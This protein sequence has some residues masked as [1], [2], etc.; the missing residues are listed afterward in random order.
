MSASDLPTLTAAAPLPSTPTALTPSPLVPGDDAAAYDT[1]LA[2]ISATVRPAD[3]IEQAWVRDVVDL[4]FEAVRLRRLKA[5]LMTACA[6]EGIAQVLRGL[7][8]PGIPSVLAQR[9]AA[10]E[11]AAVAE[12]DAALEAAG[13]TLDHVMAQTLA[14]RINE[15]ER[16]DRMIAAAEARRNTALRE[17]AHHRATFAASLRDAA[18]HAVTDAEFE[19]VGAATTG[20]TAAADAVEAAAEAAA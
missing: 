3:L 6:G 16:I 5:A 18:A 2:G 14:L 1:L 20:E 4:I 10:R 17:I 19:V 11:L 9:W 15:I 12:V 13:L 7:D 8:V